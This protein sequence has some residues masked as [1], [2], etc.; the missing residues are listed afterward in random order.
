MA[1]RGVGVAAA[2]ELVARQAFGDAGL[3]LVADRADV[4]DELAGAGRQRDRPDHPAQPFDGAHDLEIELRHAIAVIGQRKALEHDI[5]EP[6]IGRG[7][8]RL[9]RGDQRVGLL[10]LIAVMDAHL[11]G[12]DIELAP[13]DPDAPDEGDRPFA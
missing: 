12:L 3:G 1:E 5:G 10:R 11:H 7:L 4:I 13:I 6:A 9:L 8:A 2:I